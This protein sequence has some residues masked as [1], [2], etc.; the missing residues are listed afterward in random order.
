MPILKNHKIP[1]LAGGGYVKANAPQL[2]MIGDN[3]HEGEI[4]SPESKLQ[5][6]ANKA[7]N[8]ANNDEVITLLR[9]ILEAL[10]DIDPDVYLDG[11]KVTDKIVKILNN[12]TRTRGN[13]GIVL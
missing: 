5:K 7:A 10:L 2:A 8:S 6:M 3:K 11:N 13:N 1:Y 9:A 12:R 4:V